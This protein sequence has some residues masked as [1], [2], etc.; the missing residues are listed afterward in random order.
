VIPQE[1]ERNIAVL[2]RSR[3]NG[4]DLGFADLRALSWQDD[5]PCLEQASQA[6]LHGLR[7]P[8]QV[9]QVRA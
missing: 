1:R 6:D 9:P 7:C 5:A 2:D 3:R 4:P 8:R